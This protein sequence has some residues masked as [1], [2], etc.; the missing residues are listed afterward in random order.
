MNQLHALFTRSQHAQ[1]YL[2]ELVRKHRIDPLPILGVQFCMQE[3]RRL[4]L[5]MPDRGPYDDDAKYKVICERALR[6]SGPQ[7]EW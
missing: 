1:Y 3:I 6:D 2:A 5:P 4:R 7:L